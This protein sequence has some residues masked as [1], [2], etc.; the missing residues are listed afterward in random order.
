MCGAPWY[1]HVVLPLVR[2]ECGSEMSVHRSRVREVQR[3]AKVP[4]EVAKYMLATLALIEQG[5]GI[6]E[7]LG[8]L[9]TDYDD[10]GELRFRLNLDQVKQLEN[11]V[12]AKKRA[13]LRDAAKSTA[14]IAKTQPVPESTEPANT[15]SKKAKRPTK[16]HQGKS[17]TFKRKT[18]RPGRV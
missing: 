1:N 3:N 13:T 9:K 15:E 18:K 7:I 10:D 6:P 11:P 12:P 5:N 16:K 8:P 4:F 2:C 14:K 17:K